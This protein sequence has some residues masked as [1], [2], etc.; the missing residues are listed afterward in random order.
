MALSCTQ[1]LHM[2]LMTHKSRSTL[3]MLY[4]L[5]SCIIE[6]SR[7]LAWPVKSKF[8][9]WI[10]ALAVKAVQLEFTEIRGSTFS[11]N[12]VT[13]S[14]DVMETTTLGSRPFRIMLKLFSIMPFFYDQLIYQL[15]HN[16]DPLFLTNIH[17]LTTLIYL[18]WLYCNI[19][20]HSI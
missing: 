18:R 15:F 7:S 6:V 16:F 5:L 14:G 10:H 9:Q 2:S 19:R 4:Y 17:T 1:K 13:I 20:E 3:T 8:F 12:G 11:R